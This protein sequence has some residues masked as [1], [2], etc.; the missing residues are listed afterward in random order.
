MTMNK[1]Y[2]KK[3]NRQSSAGLVIIT[4]QHLHGPQRKAKIP[5][6][7]YADACPSSKTK[8]PDASN[9]P[10]DTSCRYCS[11]NFLIFPRS[12]IVHGTGDVA[13]W[14]IIFSTI[15]WCVLCANECT[16]QVIAR[17]QSA[18]APEANLFVILHNR[19]LS[20]SLSSHC[21]LS[22]WSA[23]T[24]AQQINRYASAARPRRIHTLCVWAYTNTMDLNEFNRMAFNRGNKQHCIE[25]ESR[26]V[27]LAC[28]VIDI[29]IASHRMNAFTV[30]KIHMRSPRLPVVAV[31]PI[32]LILYIFFFASSY[33]K[34][35]SQWSQYCSVLYAST[36][37]NGLKCGACQIR[38]DSTVWR[39]NKNR[40]I[41]VLRDAARN[42]FRS[43]YF[44]YY[45]S[46]C[47]SVTIAEAFLVCA[48]KAPSF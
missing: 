24:F 25:L 1:K 3:T 5:L 28:A 17:R 11:T 42:Q 10:L 38:F 44:H 6:T 43:Q 36:S 22:E 20:H 34:T 21:H 35:G 4:Q 19:W 33:Q 18:I 26:S 12:V 27:C 32:C 2:E 39:I 15:D 47:V 23:R 14:Q 37:V 9:R 30:H 7:L 16:V 29:Y 13:K 48:T 41:L 8:M 31:C 45:Y 46:A 40:N